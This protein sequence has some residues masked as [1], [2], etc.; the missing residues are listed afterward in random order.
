MGRDENI[1]IADDYVCQYTVELLVLITTSLS[2][3][4]SAPQTSPVRPSSWRTLLQDLARRKLQ[5][6][7]AM[8]QNELEHLNQ[9]RSTIPYPCHPQI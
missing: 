3:P 7:V 9:N 8:D 1:S 6:S 2:V 4:D 5:T